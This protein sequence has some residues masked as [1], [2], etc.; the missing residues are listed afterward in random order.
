M[1]PGT[2]RWLDGKHKCTV[3]RAH[4]KDSSTYKVKTD[5]K[6]VSKVRAHR[7]LSYRSCDSDT[8]DEAV[9]TNTVRAVCLIPSTRK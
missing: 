9:L 2:I 5:T 6:Y 4:T 8:E 1:L 7:P 3:I